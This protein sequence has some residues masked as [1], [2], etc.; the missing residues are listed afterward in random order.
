MP[1]IPI[2]LHVEHLRVRTG[3]DDPPPH[4]LPCRQRRRQRLGDTFGL[5]QFGVV[6]VL[7]VGTRTADETAH[8]PD[9]GMMY[10]EARATRHPTG[11]R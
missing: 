3:T 1:T 8:Y 4:G 9:I 10:C 2:A 5:T 7:E 11:G 6:R